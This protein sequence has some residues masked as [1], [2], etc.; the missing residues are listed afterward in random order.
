MR[1]KTVSASRKTGR[2][3]FDFDL[4]LLLQLEPEMQGMQGRCRRCGAAHPEVGVEVEATE[5]WPELKEM[6]MAGG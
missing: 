2:F 4:H 3:G 6:E 5:K 1:R